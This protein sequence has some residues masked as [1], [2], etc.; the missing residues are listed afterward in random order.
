MRGADQLLGV[1]ALAVLESCFE[2]IR[3]FLEY[4]G[5]GGNGAAAILDAT[6]P[7]C[8]CFLCR[9]DRSLS[10]NCCSWIG[11]RLRVDADKKLLDCAQNHG[12]SVRLLTDRH[13]SDAC[14]HFSSTGASV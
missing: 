8:P 5:F 2:S 6:L 4:A 10:V 1:G 9:H 7:H 11:C 13:Y 12:G 3:R 14:R